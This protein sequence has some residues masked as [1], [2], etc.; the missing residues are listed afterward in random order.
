MMAQKKIKE[1]K[2]NV[3][4]NKNIKSNYVYGSKYQ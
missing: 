2:V 4:S 3:N 1:E